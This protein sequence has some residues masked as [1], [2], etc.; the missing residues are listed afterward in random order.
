MDGRPALSSS[1]GEGLAS[2]SIETADTSLPRRTAISSARMLIGDL[3]GGDGADVEADGGVDAR[4]AS[5]GMPSAA[6]ASK[7]RAT[8]ARLPI[9]PR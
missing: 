7:M 5:S 2:T 9:S 8:L 1:P 3:G 6:S 4:Q